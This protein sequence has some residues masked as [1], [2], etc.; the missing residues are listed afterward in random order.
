MISLKRKL[1]W[2]LGLGWFT[3]A[4][5]QN[6]NPALVEV[7]AS[8]HT[9]SRGVAVSQVSLSEEQIRAVGLEWGTPD[10]RQMG[11]NIE[12][13]A[14]VVVPPQNRAS[15]HAKAEGF[16]KTIRVSEG[17]YVHQGQSLAT[18]ENSR[19]VQL[20]EQYLVVKSE[21]EYLQQE[22]DRQHTLRN[23]NINAAKTLEKTRSELAIS[24]ARKASLAK[25][26]QFLGL[27]AEGLKE[28]QLSHLLEVTAPISGYIQSIAVHLGEF[29]PSGQPLF[30]MSADQ[31]K[32][33][34]MAIFARDIHR[35]K[36]GQK[37][38]FRI[39][40]AETEAYEARILPI[41]QSFDEARK[42]IR[43]YAYI[44][45]PGVAS[46]LIPGLYARAR[47]L[48]DEQSFMALPQEAIVQEG[49]L[50]YVFVKESSYPME[51]R[52]ARY[53]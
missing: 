23:E 47:I 30:E 16:I 42:T 22:Y 7:E 8:N 32:H 49:D 33:L 37:V 25:Q 52:S 10:R 28:T 4:C 29:A 31:P 3:L 15:V 18:L 26:L 39:P 21:L 51:L 36:E 11:A 20:Q 50:S 12:V 2:G 6:P 19:Y 1:V 14:W 27:P 9:E 45:D 41:G 46:R 38:L 53:R 13:A 44:A 35:V 5:G 17:A 24:K 48:A 43:V 34:E 40:N